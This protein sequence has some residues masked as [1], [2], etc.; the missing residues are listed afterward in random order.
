MNAP[1]VYSHDDF[2][3]H[4]MN[5][6]IHAA[7]FINS[8][9]VPRPIAFITSISPGGIINAAP[10]SYFNVACTNPAMVSIAVERR[11][12]VR[13]DTSRNIAD[14]KEFVINLCSVDL[15][16]AVSIAGGDYLPTISE[17]D[18]TDLSLIPSEKIAVPRIANTKV[19]LE[20]TLFQII[21]LGNDPTDLI[22]GKIVNVHIHKE[23]IDPKK[24]I[25]ISKLNPLGRLAGS[26][27]AELGSFFDI[28]RGLPAKE[29]LPLS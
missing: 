23:L 29:G 2:I 3:L 8:L 1:P 17:I 28:P 6:P 7:S 14:T 16:K 19:Q 12:G 20:C 18:L 11:N 10:F 5:G 24:R 27:Y 21:E 4:E 13:K 22:L 9:I 15:A 26:T 25:D